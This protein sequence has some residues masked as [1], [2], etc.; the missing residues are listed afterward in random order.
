MFL[1][2]L[3]EYFERGENELGLTHVD[4]LVLGGFRLRVGLSA[5]RAALELIRHFRRSCEN[6][7]RK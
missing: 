4:E 3:K 2:R 6:F 7:N 5:G 1:S